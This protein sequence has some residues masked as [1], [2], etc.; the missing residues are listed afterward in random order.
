M[1]HIKIVAVLTIMASGV[2]AQADTLWTRTYGGSDFDKGYSVQQT[3]DGGFIIVGFTESYGAG[4]EDVYLIKTDENGDTLWTRT[5]GG[6]S[7][8]MGNSVQETTDGGFIIAG[9]TYSYGAG[10]S[11]VYLIRTDSLGDTL[12]TRTYGGS[13]D[14]YGYSV[15]QCQDGGFIIA[16]KTESYGAGYY[17]V[18]LIRTDSMGDTLWTK[19]YGGSDD[20]EG[21]SVQQCQDGGFIIA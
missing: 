9:Y 14:D 6:S 19:T 10:G 11:G 3:Q 13:D 18:Y 8:D 20:D 21:Y 5:Y 4:G 1:K 15:Q 16:G 17:D 12:W 7:D 2:Y